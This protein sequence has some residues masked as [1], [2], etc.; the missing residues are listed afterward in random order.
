MKKNKSIQGKKGFTPLEIYYKKISPAGLT[1]LEINSK[2]KSLTGFTLMEVLLSLGIFTV[3][4]VSSLYVLS[5]AH[6]LSTQSRERLL[7]LTAA[8]STVEAIK[9]TP[10]VNI[11][12]I[13]TAAFIPPGLRNGNITI[14]TNPGLISAN[15]QNATITVTVT[16]TGPKNIPQRLDITTMR[17]RF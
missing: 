16:W 5:S 2:K 15:T 3:V 7:A 10:L 17:S 11:R 4:L 6:Q 1:P 8:R 9:N 13:T 14:L 12:S